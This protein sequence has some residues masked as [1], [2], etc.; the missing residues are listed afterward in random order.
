MQ[1]PVSELP[2]VCNLYCCVSCRRELDSTM[3]SMQKEITKVSEALKTYQSVGMGFD[4]LVQE[5]TQL[6]DEIENKKW[7]LRELRVSQN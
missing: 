3:S 5:F 6:R 4:D 1:R 2:A 7:A